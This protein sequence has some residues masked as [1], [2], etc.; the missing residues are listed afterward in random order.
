[1][2]WTQVLCF[3]LPFTTSIVSSQAT[4][5]APLKFNVFPIYFGVRFATWPTDMRNKR[6]LELSTMHASHWTKQTLVT[7]CCNNRQP[8][9][10]IDAR[11]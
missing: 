5:K 8:T 2:A 10:A 3:F 9:D 6:R 4:V 1:M 11:T 7:A